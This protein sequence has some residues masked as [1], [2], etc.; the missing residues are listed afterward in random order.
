[1]TLARWIS[2]IMAIP[3]AAIAVVRLPGKECFSL[4]L[5]LFVALLLIWFPRDVNEMTLGLWH[6]G[7]KIDAP[8]PPLMIAAVGWA[9][10][11]AVSFAVAAGFDA[12]TDP[13]SH[14]VS[15]AIAV[16][17]PPPMHSAATPRL[18]PRSRRAWSNIATM[19]APVAPTG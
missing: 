14:T 4:S 2:L 16:A 15:N 13:P 17:S 12:A 3:A 6:A 11:I 19:R 5:A 8:T 18:R 1:V 9:I 7:Y 10:L